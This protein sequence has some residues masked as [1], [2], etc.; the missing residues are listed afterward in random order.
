MRTTLRAFV[1]AAILPLALAA[2]VRAQEEEGKKLKVGKMAPADSLSHVDYVQGSQLGPLVGN[3]VTVVEFW[4]TWCGPCKVSIPHLNQLYIDLAPRGL[5]VLGVS[6]EPISKV[7]PFVKDKGSQMTYAVAC[8]KQDDET[9]KEKWMAAA[10]QNGIPC[11][12]I[13]SRAGKVC[14]IGHPMDPQF[15]RVLKLTLANRYDPELTSRVEPTV[16][17]A[18]KAAKIRNYKEAER[19]YDEALKEG[20][21]VLVDVG[22]EAW[23]MRAEQA[24]NGAAAKEYAAKL[25]DMVSKDK[26]ALM[27]IAEYLATSPDLTNNLRD[28]DAAQLAADKVKA[29]ASSDDADALAVVASVAAARGDLNAAYEM[30]YDAWMAAPP[31]AKP[32]LKR[33]LDTYNDARKKAGASAK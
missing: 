20:P 30:Q 17:A 12:F 16:A 5:Q 6:D 13:V 7:K 33:A 28:L 14:F 8:Q 11:A 4:A 15:E 27:A 24:N 21:S 3:K 29:A 10:G 9:M 23:K 1:L 19:L 18:R 31:S 22:L 26:F 2:T 25:I 32:A